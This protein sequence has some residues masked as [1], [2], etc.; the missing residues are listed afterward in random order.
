M[1]NFMKTHKYF[2]D[3]IDATSAAPYYSVCQVSSLLCRHDDIPPVKGRCSNQ[4][5]R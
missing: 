3:C 4:E 5:G 1:A 2:M